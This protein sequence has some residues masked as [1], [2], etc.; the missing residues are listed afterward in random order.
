MVRLTY[1]TLGWVRLGLRLH[2]VR[3]KT[4]QYKDKG[5]DKDKANDKDTDTDKDK[6]KDKDKDSQ[7]NRQ[8]GGTQRQTR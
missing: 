7:A 3:H 6:D 8:N 2:S 5:K 4:R 1:V